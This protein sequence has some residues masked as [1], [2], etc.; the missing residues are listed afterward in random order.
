MSTSY[1][2]S[3]KATEDLEEIWLHTYFHWSEKQADK[4]YNI[5]IENIELVA[6]NINIGRNV[7]YI[8]MGDRC[9]PVEQHLIF[10]TITTENIV[11]I[12]RILHQKMDTLSRLK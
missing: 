1:I 5:L 9:L 2:I 3:Q 12:I 7:D 10:Y 4:Y 6:Q 11:K 8:K